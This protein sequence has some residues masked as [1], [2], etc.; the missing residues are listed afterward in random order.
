MGVTKP[1]LLK[2]YLR[3]FERYIGMYY[4]FRV[5]KVKRRLDQQPDQNTH[6]PSKRLNPS[7]APQKTKNIE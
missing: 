6:S 3:D 2:D 5:S 7:T 4:D 1:S